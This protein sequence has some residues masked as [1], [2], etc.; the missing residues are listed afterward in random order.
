MYQWIHLVLAD[1]L[2]Y[3]GRRLILVRPHEP[4]CPTT[5]PYT[6]PSVAAWELR[7]IGIFL[8]MYTF[9]VV[10]PQSVSTEQF[11]N[12]INC[13]RVSVE[14]VLDDETLYVKVDGDLI[15]VCSSAGDMSTP[16]TFVEL[17]NKIKGCFCDATGS[18]YPEFECV[19]PKEEHKKQTQKTSR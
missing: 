7:K 12:A 2:A 5:R 10:K 3:D 14:S 17:Q 15:I 4:S 18:I 16:M 6:S 8:R 9:R 19:I 1:Q 13:A 11:E